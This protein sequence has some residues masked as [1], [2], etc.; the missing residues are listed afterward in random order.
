MEKE[1]KEGLAALKGHLV[2]CH[3]ALKDAEACHKETEASLKDAAESHTKHK[4]AYKEARFH[5]KNAME[6]M[7][8]DEADEG[9]TGDEEPAG[10]GT[11]DEKPR[12]SVELN[13]ELLE[14]ALKGEENA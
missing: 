3:K 5:M 1:V 4:D 9:G 8:E 12:K 2:K 13:M 7:K 14:K 6:S 11:G 10:D